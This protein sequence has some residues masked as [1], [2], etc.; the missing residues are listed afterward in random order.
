MDLKRVRTDKAPLPIGPYEQAVVVGNIVF[1]SGQIGLDPSTGELVPGGVEAEAGRVFESLSHILDSAGSSA[2]RVIK[3]TLYLRD[4]A[5]FS[6]VN[7]IYESFFGEV[8][9]ARTTVQVSA[10]PRGAAIEVDAVG[11]VGTL[12]KTLSH[13]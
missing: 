12:D 13:P 9:P 4:L 5:A 2:K 10:L 1:T 7:E 6:K 8:K 11:L 3:T